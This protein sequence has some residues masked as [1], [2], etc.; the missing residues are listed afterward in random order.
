[1][2]VCC[3]LLRA[4]AYD[5]H[6]QMQIA[7]PQGYVPFSMCPPSPKCRRHIDTGGKTPVLRS[8]QAGMTRTLK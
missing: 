6:L 5:D 4:M 2:A 3:V 1:M 7:T 8:T